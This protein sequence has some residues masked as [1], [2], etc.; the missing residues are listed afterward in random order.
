MLGLCVGDGTPAGVQSVE[1]DEVLLAPGVAA[2]GLS[3]AG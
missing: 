1:E 3:A 2:A